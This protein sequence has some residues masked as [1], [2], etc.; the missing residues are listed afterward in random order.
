MTDVAY[1]IGGS[2]SAEDRRAEERTL[3]GEYRDALEA[4]GV[5]D[6]EWERCWLE[7]RRQVFLGILMT[8]APAMVVQRTDRGDE[9]FLT[10]LARYAQQALEL[11]SLDLLPAPGT[12]GPPRSGP[13]PRRRAATSRPRGGAVE[14]ELVFRRHLR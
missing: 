1:F 8:V 5:R 13:R 10:T 2:L 6:F 12:G 14:R 9:M 7:Y 4:E 3:V 11:D